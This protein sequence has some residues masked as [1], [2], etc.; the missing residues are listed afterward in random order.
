MSI[1]SWGLCRV[2]K[3]ASPPL[4]LCNCDS[5]AAWRCPCWPFVRRYT[6]KS[7]FPDKIARLPARN[8]S[9]LGNKGLLGS[10]CLIGKRRSMLHCLLAPSSPSDGLSTSDLWHRAHWVQG[11]SVPDTVGAAHTPCLNPDSQW[12]HWHSNGGWQWRQSVR[13]YQRVVSIFPWPQ[14]EC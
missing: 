12:P 6:K 10:H 11:S 7:C 5:C 14:D 9:I 3:W 8:R 2:P 4:S 1:R 13:I